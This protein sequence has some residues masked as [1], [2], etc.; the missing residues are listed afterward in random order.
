MTNYRCEGCSSTNRERHGGMTD[1][2][3]FCEDMIQNNKEK[4]KLGERDVLLFRIYLQQFIHMSYIKNLIRKKDSSYY[5]KDSSALGN[6]EG[7]KN[8][9]ASVTSRFKRYNDRDKSPF[10]WNNNTSPTKGGDKPTMDLQYVMRM[11]K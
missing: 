10:T 8:Q 5:R 3:V 1:F 4:F 9:T 7:E 6:G 11:K 2:E